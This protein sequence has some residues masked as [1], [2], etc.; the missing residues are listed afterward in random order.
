MGIGSEDL[1]SRSNDDF[2]AQIPKRN[3]PSSLSPLSSRYSRIRQ[4]EM[5]CRKRED[6]AERVERACRPPRPSVF[7][8]SYI[9]HTLCRIRALLYF[10][11]C[12]TV[13]QCVTLSSSRAFLSS[14]RPRVVIA[15]NPKWTVKRIARD[16]FRTYFSVSF[17]L[18]F[19]LPLTL[20][21]FA[22]NNPVQFRHDLS[23]AL[24]VVAPPNFFRIVGANK[25]GPHFV[26]RSIY[27][28]E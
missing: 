5:A 2:L 14:S 8:D 1:L 27:L 22:V 3:P 18:L 12:R 26:L 11:L 17:F 9:C 21:Q 23:S 6:G 25:L 28:P 10:A 24:C 13:F 7:R 15:V 19:S 20:Q 16:R 4:A